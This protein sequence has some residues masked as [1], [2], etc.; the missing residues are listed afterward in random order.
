[1]QDN[2]VR[3][4]V[5]G[6]AMMR[7]VIRADKVLVLRAR[8]SIR[9]QASHPDA[10]QFSYNGSPMTP[11]DKGAN[12]VERGG[13]LTLIVPPEVANTLTDPF[14]GESPIKGRFVPAPRVSPSPAAPSP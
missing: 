5:D 1:M 2:W 7:F 10:I 3:Y 9:F 4:Q 6:R 12:V 8:E 13:D 11:V 14:P